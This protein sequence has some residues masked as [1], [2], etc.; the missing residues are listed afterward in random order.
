MSE[1]N[2]A[3]AKGV[4]AFCPNLDLL[5]W[6]KQPTHYPQV[7]PIHGMSYSIE[8]GGNRDMPF[9]PTHRQTNA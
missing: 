3:T 5:K 8:V 2:A 1:K 4:K 9:S 6:V 7:K